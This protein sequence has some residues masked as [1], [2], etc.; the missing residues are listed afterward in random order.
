M[1]PNPG[2]HF[3][4]AHPAW[5]GQRDRTGSRRE[6]SG[7]LPGKTQ[8]HFIFHKLPSAL[9]KSGAWRAEWDFCNLTC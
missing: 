2:A 1:G 8:G 3:T 7:P 4:A 5:G 9:K 6:A